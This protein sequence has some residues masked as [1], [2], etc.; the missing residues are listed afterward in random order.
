MDDLLEIAQEFDIFITY[1][2]TSYVKS[3][4]VRFDEK[5]YI[6]L[7]EELI[8]NEKEEK[9][10]LAHEIG[11]CTMQNSYYNADTSIY[12]RKRREYKADTKAAELT[13]DIEQLKKAIKKGIDTTWELSEYFEIPEEAVTR[14]IQ[15][16]KNKGL[17]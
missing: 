7:N 14:S 1:K 12:A 17:L 3:M 11:H 9:W 16:Y 10:C 5:D 6:N 15:I 4:A 8:E 2:K 13:I